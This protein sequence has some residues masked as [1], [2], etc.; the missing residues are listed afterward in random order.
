MN[1]VTGYRKKQQ[2][3]CRAACV[4]AALI[5]VCGIG[6]AADTAALKHAC[7][8]LKGQTIAG[9]SIADAALVTPP[10][11]RVG[12]FCK[13]KGRIHGSLGFQIRLPSKW[14]NKL[15]YVGGGGMDGVI[16]EE[17]LAGNAGYAQ[18]ASDG[19]HQANMTDAAWA[20]RNPQ[21]QQDYAYLSV[22]TVLEAANAIITKHYGVPIKQRYFE[23][24]SNGG[25]EALIAAT[26]FPHDFDGV[27]ARAPA[28]N[29]TWL[30]QAFNRNVKQ[31]LSTPDAALTA[32]TLKTLGDAI[33][34]KCDAMDGLK[35]GVVSNFTACTFDPAELR[36]AGE[37]NDQCL[38]NGQIDTVNTLF[39]ASK[40]P[41][42]TEY[43]PEWRPSGDEGNPSPVGLGAFL[44]AD[45]PWPHG[46]DQGGPPPVLSHPHSTASGFRF[47]AGVIN[48]FLLGDPQYDS[49]KFQP[50]DHLPE[51]NLLSV[52]L[53]ATPDL[54]TFFALGHKLILW[55][56]TGDGAI[57]YKSSIQYFNAIADAV[58]GEAV[59]DASMAFYL[60]PGAAH[61]VGGN[62]PD[63]V[64]LMTPL[65]A[66][67][68]GNQRP[69]KSKLVTRKIDFTTGKVAASRPLCPYPAYPRYIGHGDPNSAASFACKLPE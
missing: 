16:H 8:S 64:D 51:L 62:G 27:I 61:C 9:A 49:L 46:F 6:H 3:N 44:I 32:G 15:V 69:S 66:W 29:I 7:Q 37:K 17:S 36:C 31:Q 10:S 50:Q 26:R 18:V 21:A 4:A 30:F 57:S 12:E 54:S 5:S 58:G 53:D 55:H 52:M 25:R 68:E 43:Y 45:A 11:G 40:L 42:G 56:G 22:H 24:C 2:G 41:N 38:T 39:T 35:D 60:A 19:G 13:I 47:Q 59:R 48:N 33:T 14:N 20:L 23:G 67:V 34:N 1:P 65:A 63:T 28:W